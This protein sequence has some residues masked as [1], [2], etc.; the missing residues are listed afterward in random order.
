MNFG[1]EHGQNIKNS[2]ENMSSE[3]GIFGWCIRIGSSRTVFK[4]KWI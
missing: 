2:E 4:M 1:S 3:N